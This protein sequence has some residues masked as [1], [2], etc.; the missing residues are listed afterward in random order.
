[1]R[2]VLSLQNAAARHCIRMMWPQ[3]AGATPVS[4]SPTSAVQARLSGASGI[5]WSNTY[6]PAWP[7]I[8]SS[9]ST[10][11]DVH[12]GLNSF[13]MWRC[14]TYERQLWRQNFWPADPRLWNN[15]PPWNILKTLSKMY[16]VIHLLTYLLTYL[17]GPFPTCVMSIWDFK[18]PW[19]VLLVEYNSSTI[20]QVSLSI[21][22]WFNIR[23]MQHFFETIALRSFLGADCWNGRSKSRRHFG[24]GTV[25]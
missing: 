14:F 3:Y 9:A 25:R 2:K 24:N 8:F 23:H 16:I 13:D 20:A 12:F 18:W 21:F 15:L 17:L 10:A 5:V 6:V 19:T 7:I 1:M 4:G 11:T 22:R